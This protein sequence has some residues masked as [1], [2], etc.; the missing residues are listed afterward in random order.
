MF[1]GKK[2]C[3]MFVAILLSGYSL[4]SPQ[5]FTGKITDTMCGKKH[6]I[7]GKSDSECTL[8]CVKAAPNGAYGLVV[9]EKVYR[10]QTNKDDIAPFAGK[11]ATVTGEAK[12]D[13]IA[14]TSVSEAK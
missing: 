1:I 7:P 12:G 5:T 11:R 2:P 10:L 4:A 3:A 13:Q 14:V 9:G 8:T 6:M